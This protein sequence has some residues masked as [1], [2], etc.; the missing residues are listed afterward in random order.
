[1]AELLGVSGRFS[2]I[3]R[4]LARPNMF[5]QT[6]E[7]HRQNLNDIV[8]SHFNEAKNRVTPVYLK[9]F[10]SPQAVFNRH[11]RHRGDIP[12][13]L[14]VLP[15]SAWRLIKSAVIRQKNHPA[16]QLHSIA[17]SGKQ[18][19]LYNVIEVEL[20]DMAGL[21]K[22]LQDYVAQYQSA[23]ACQLSDLLNRLPGNQRKEVESRL[24][25]HIERLSVPVEGSREAV[26]FLLTGLMGK[27]LGASGFG[28][29]LA[30]GQAAAT[31]IYTSNLSWWGGLWVSLTGVPGWVSVAGATSGLLATLLIAPFFA[32]LLEVGIN[33]FRGKKMLSEI[34]EQVRKRVIKPPSNTVDILGKLAVYLQLLP[35][36][37]NVAAKIKL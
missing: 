30:T 10:A 37:L 9:H 5:V 31:A 2:V 8:E 17:L 33:R 34:I 12:G 1:M 7:E 23:F 6:I 32:P 13:E 36:I 26:M 15:R 14:A 27:S 21:D 18:L 25:H 3:F 16:G 28:S 29:S 19:E 24:A 4:W 22:K 11:W 35:D 20:L